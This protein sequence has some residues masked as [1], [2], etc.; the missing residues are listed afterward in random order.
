MK[1]TNAPYINRIAKIMGVEPENVKLMQPDT[2]ALSEKA[3]IQKGAEAIRNVSEKNVGDIRKILW[4]FGGYDEQMK[5]LSA[6]DANGNLIAAAPPAGKAGTV[7]NP[8]MPK[9]K[10]INAILGDIAN[11]SNNKQQVFETLHAYTYAETKEGKSFLNNILMKKH[12]N[13]INELR[14]QKYVELIDG[15]PVVSESLPD[16]HIRS[17]RDDLISKAIKKEQELGISAEN[18]IRNISQKAKLSLETS[19]APKTI[20]VPEVPKAQIVEK[21]L[22]LM[23]EVEKKIE[24]L[25]NKYYPRAINGMIRSAAEQDKRYEGFM[26]LATALKKSEPVDRFSPQSD[27]IKAELKIAQDHLKPQQF[28][29]VLEGFADVKTVDGGTFFD[30]QLSDLYRSTLKE[31]KLIEH[32]RVTMLEKIDDINLNAVDKIN[33]IRDKRDATKSK[34]VH[35][36]NKKLAK[37]HKKAAKQRAKVNKFINNKFNKLENSKKMQVTQENKL[38]IINIKN[39]RLEAIQTN[40][41]A[42]LSELQEKIRPKEDALKPNILQRTFTRKK[43]TERLD[44]VNLAAK[45]KITEISNKAR[46]QTELLKEMAE[47]SVTKA[48]LRKFLSTLYKKIAA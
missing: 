15:V 19:F 24:V 9:A 13:L 29:N 5:V 3:R 12:N 25:R 44:E 38:E 43:I 16:K 41:E 28:F 35:R 6:T 10:E 20:A 14:P 45:K 23:S 34:I 39:E 4:S 26:D 30:S 32:Q 27:T 31:V 33:D 11:N 7:I 40:L 1:V 2:L 42:R 17:Y 36:T 37:A 18:R 47:T 48:R 8:N 46:I 22:N 21:K